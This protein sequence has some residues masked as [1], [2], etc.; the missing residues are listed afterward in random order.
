LK[1]PDEALKRISGLTTT[2][3]NALNMLGALLAV[4]AYKAKSGKKPQITDDDIQHCCNWR[5]VEAL[6]YY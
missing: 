6:S 5:V 4:A 1:I 3:G 2:P